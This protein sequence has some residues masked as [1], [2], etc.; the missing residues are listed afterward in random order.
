MVKKIKTKESSKTVKTSDKKRNLQH[1]EKKIILSQKDMVVPKNSNEKEQDNQYAVNK[2]VAVEKKAFQTAFKK[3][4]LSVRKKKD[5][6]NQVFDTLSLKK[7]SDDLNEDKLNIKN[8]EKIQTKKIKDLNFIRQKK[9]DQYSPIK[10]KENESKTIIN[11]SDSY[12]SRMKNYWIAG[13]KNKLKNLKNR[14]KTVNVVSSLGSGVFHGGTFIYKKAKNGINFLITAG[15]GLIILIVITLFIGLFS[16]LSDD[17]T[18]VN[19]EAYVS[20]EV[21][22]YTEVIEK[23][24]VEYNIADYVPLIQAV[25]MQESGGKGKDPMQSSECGFNEKYPRKPGGITDPDYSIQVGIQNL[26][27]CLDKAKVKEISDIDNISLA[28]QGYNYGNGYI[29]WAVKNFGG[30][31]KANAKVF[32]DQKKAELKTDVYGDPDYVPHVLRY[33][34]PGQGGIVLA[35]KS[36]VGTAGGKKY[37]EWY[38]LNQRVNWCAIFVSWC[39]YE[40]GDI[41]TNIPKFAATYDGMAW[42]TRHNKWKDKSYT[43][44]P[45]DIIF[46]DWE[47]NKLPDH[48][49]I[50]VK[51]EDGKIYTVEGNSNDEVKSKEYDKNYKHILGYGIRLR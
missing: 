20:E 24:A 25:M 26:A 7:D 10:S 41:G 16:A 6:N 36:Q 23:Y 11:H 28:L 3:R 18:T 34:H 44:V 19:A 9:A 17:T 21:L 35:A 39:A 42:F 32:S 22:A 14:N 37:W 51:V 31:T 40:S 45:G 13:Y 4:R 38:G 50:V 43:P 47:D 48:V 49:G 1:F 46:F 30:Y 12:T 15:T 29:S 33:Y 27:D 8:K 5:H 2:T